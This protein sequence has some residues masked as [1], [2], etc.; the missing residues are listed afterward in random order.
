LRLLHL[1]AWPISRP[2]QRL[3]GVRRLE[4]NARRWRLCVSRLDL[5]G[6]LAL[7]MPCA[8]SMPTS[9]P[10]RPR[11]GWPCLGIVT[12]VWSQGRFFKTSLRARACRSSCPTRASR[13]R[14]AGWRR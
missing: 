13:A 9:K 14:R 7:G 11:F 10:G 2:V 5:R 8:A 4:R 6:D 3:A 12:Q 1:G